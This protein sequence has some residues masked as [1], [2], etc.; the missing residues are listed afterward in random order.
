ME[1]PDEVRIYAAGHIMLESAARDQGAS[2]PRERLSL[3]EHLAGK[4][5]DL[6]SAR[7][8]DAGATERRF[9]CLNPL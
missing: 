8:A 7:C 9:S 5:F 2:S 1:E 3:P 6:L 4:N